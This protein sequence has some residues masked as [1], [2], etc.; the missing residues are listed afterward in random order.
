LPDS[1]RITNDDAMTA[2]DARLALISRRQLKSTFSCL[3]ARSLSVPPS[4]PAYV[5]YKP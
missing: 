5:S 2:A 3:P 4:R 1:S